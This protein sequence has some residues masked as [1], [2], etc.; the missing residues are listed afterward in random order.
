[1][2]GMA[3]LIKKAIH[4]IEKNSSEHAAYL[5]SGTPETSLQSHPEYM[6][7]SLD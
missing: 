3:Y 7:I 4:V 2:L 1:M 6:T 5:C